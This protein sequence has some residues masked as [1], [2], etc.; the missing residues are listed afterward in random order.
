MLTT[1]PQIRISDNPTTLFF[2]A[3]DELGFVTHAFTFRVASADGDLKGAVH[4][5]AIR[6]YH[7]RVLQSLGFSRRQL[8]VCEQVHGN[9]V[10]AV[11]ERPD[12][13]V[14]KVDGLVTNQR[15]LPLGIY[16][17]DCSAVFIVDR[18]TPAI[19]LLHSGKLGTQL[20]ITGEALELME[21]S[22]GT[23]PADCLAV[24]SPSI[25]PCH[26]E[27]DIWWAIELQLRTAGVR[28]IVNPR[29]CTA[30]HV[31]QFYSY[32]AEKGK[33]GRLLAVL[34]LR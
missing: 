6:E 14:A 22:F 26:Y 34:A 21:K 20:N 30:C 31:D 24:L 19:A 2:P 13:P 28:E 16:A 9:R 27:M 25:G 4:Q 29:I 23:N 7:E 32:R 8:A 17:A 11:N 15:G 18:K 5:T 33:T 10:A 12:L 1:N 3:L